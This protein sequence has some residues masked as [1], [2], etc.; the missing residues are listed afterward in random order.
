[1]QCSAVQYG[2]KVY[3]AVVAYLADFFGLH[4]VC[5]LSDGIVAMVVYTCKQKIVGKL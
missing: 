2:R 3:S 4:C 5:A 1:M